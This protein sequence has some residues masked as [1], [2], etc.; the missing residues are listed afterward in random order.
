MTAEQILPR[1]E[2]WKARHEALSSACYQLEAL[3]GAA[4]DC[5]LLAPV[6]ALWNAYTEA[7]SGLIGD[8]LGRLN[9][10]AVQCEMGA[11]PRTTRLA[12]GREIIVYT[13]VDLV[14]VII[15]DQ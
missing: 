14:T 13:L 11:M 4:P 10:Y 1:L 12:D 7:V 2:A 8:Q 9:W 5:R 15:G 6:H 3:T